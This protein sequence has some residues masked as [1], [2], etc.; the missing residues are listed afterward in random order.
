MNPIKKKDFFHRLGTKFYLWVILFIIIPVC[1]VFIYSFKAFEGIMK[2]EVS[3]RSI[4]NIA[5]IENEIN[6]MFDNIVK[7][8]NVVSN[9]ETIQKALMDTSLSYYDRTVAI[10]KVLNNLIDSNVILNKV[11]ITIFDKQSNVFS[12]WSLNYNDYQFLYREDWVQQAVKYNGHLVWRL[13]E[14]SF[15]KEDT[16]KNY[17]SLARI[18]NGS[19]GGG[20]NAG[21]LIVSVSEEAFIELFQK[22]KYISSKDDCVI[23]TNNKNKIIMSLDNTDISGKREVS[24]LLNEIS[25]QDRG[26]MLREVENKKY[27]VNYYTITRVPWTFENSEWKVTVFTLYDKII[28]KLKAFSSQI[29]LF[30]GAF[31]LAV[32]IIAGILTSKIVK[33]IQRLNKKMLRFNL[34]SELTGLDIDRKDEI[35]HLNLAFYKMAENIKELFDKLKTEHSIREK[36]RFESL[37]AQLNPHFLFNTLNTIRWMAIIRQ[38]DNI[39]EN[40]DALANLLKFSMSRGSEIVT[41]QEEIE[42]IKS[43]VLI[44]NSR[45]GGKYEL[46]VEVDP[47]LLDM[48]IIRFILQ[49]AVE[50][51]II[52]AYKDTDRQGCILIK[53]DGEGDNLAL[54]VM[55]DG[56]GISAEVLAGIMVEEGEDGRD[57]KKITGIGLKI[58]NER[59][60]MSYGPQYGVEIQSEE[61]RGTVVKYTLPMIIEG[62]G[63]IA[64]GNAG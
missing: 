59:I 34:E 23:I 24:E 2:E 1:C 29:I 31:I 3:Q 30:F 54:Y 43:Y 7:V 4:E 57:E 19:A 21:V 50:N 60:K 48:K 53:A 37:R 40:I 14:P 56:A 42:H 41:L 44:Q 61:G 11:K 63:K 55:D 20:T 26:Y 62:G 18:I 36:Y 47:V 16:A 5:G 25:R 52:H 17:I 10:D 38:A 33:P 39:V 6:N 28:Y 15:I 35:G 45:Y 22:N 51:A 49:P 64:E 46:C 12:N 9:D 13:F 58:V 27:L 32:L 8:S